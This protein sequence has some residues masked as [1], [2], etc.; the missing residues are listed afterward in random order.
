MSIDIVPEK[1][2]QSVAQAPS[3]QPK[4]LP[5]DPSQT[6]PWP[7][8]AVEPVQVRWRYAI[9]IPLIHLLACL[10]FVPWFFSWTGVALSILGLYVFGTLGINIGYHRLLT[11]RG[12]N[13]PKWF[14][15]TLA[16]LGVCTMQDTPACWVAMHRIHHQHGRH[17]NNYGDITWWDMLFG[18]YENPPEWQDRCGFDDDKEQ[19]LV[20]MLAYRDVHD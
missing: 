19:Q 10:A 2:T 7:E 13:A 16:L 1:P 6:L 14:E 17:R 9:S 20:R 4:V 5:A 8:T 12:M 11:H 15:H 3:N 18:T